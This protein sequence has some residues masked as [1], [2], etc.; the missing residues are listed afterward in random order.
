MKTTDVIETHNRNKNK[1]E[2]NFKEL[3]SSSEQTAREAL[4]LF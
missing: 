1:D 2:R 3:K 4:A